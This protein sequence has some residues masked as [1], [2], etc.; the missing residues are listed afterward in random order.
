MNVSAALTM[1]R[2]MNGEKLVITFVPC[3][4]H[5]GTGE[6]KHNFCVVGVVVTENPVR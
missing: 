5:L 2:V 6:S 3:C 4:R 1:I